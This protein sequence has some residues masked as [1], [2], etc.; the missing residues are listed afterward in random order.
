M[1]VILIFCLIILS[2]SAYSQSYQIVGKGNDGSIKC[3][4][5]IYETSN[6]DSNFDILNKIE[7]NINDMGLITYHICNK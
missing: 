5:K 3:T 1:K 2:F 4:G 7:T 6:Y